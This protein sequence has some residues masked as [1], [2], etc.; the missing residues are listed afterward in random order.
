M[1]CP[2]LSEWFISSFVQV[3]GHDLS[4]MNLVMGQFHTQGISLNHEW[5][6][7]Y[8]ATFD[9]ASSMNSYDVAVRLQDG[10]LD[11]DWMG[12]GWPSIQLCNISI[13]VA[14]F[15][16][17]KSDPSIY[18]EQRAH[19][20]RPTFGRTLFVSCFFCSIHPQGHLWSNNSDASSLSKITKL[21]H[22][23]ID[24]VMTHNSWHLCCSGPWVWSL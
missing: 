19:W 22:K 7:L 15:K 12:L 18:V 2:F 5:Q 20:T 3:N 1:C 4:V 8:D 13:L 10:C 24:W 9:D 17:S 6:A 11:Y 16:I 23:R 14:Y 21:K